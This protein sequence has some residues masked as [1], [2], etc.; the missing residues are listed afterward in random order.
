M[1]KI[2][3]A[4]VGSLGI[5]LAAAVAFAAPG[6]MGPGM[7]MHGPMGGMMSHDAA[8]GADMATVHELLVDHEGIR[9]TVTNLSNGIRTVT[10]SDDPR[11]AGF[12]RAHVASMERR[13]ADGRPFNMF[14]PTLPILFANKDRIETAVEATAKG[15]VVTQTSS[16][17]KV[18]AALQ[19]HAGEVSKLARDG[20]AAMMRSA[21]ASMA[22]TPGSPSQLPM[23]DPVAHGHAAGPGGDAP[24]ADRRMEVEFPPELRDHT[25]ANMRDH[26]RTLQEIQATLAAG[27]L[28][29]AADI[30]ERRL[31]MS[32]LAAHGAHEVA[33]YMP[34]GMQNAGSAMHRSASRFAIAA[35]DASAT[36]DLKPA[37]AALAEVTA[38]CVACHAA[39]RL[40]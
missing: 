14:S 28:D 21:Q 36:S 31:G 10:E 9:R 39:Y 26:L 22:A 8:S 24:A 11:L 4:V 16:D 40:K 35:Q 27:K 5:A 6:G 30:A 3:I 25:L 1:G 17:P 13:L 33:K 12:I 18:V 37:L 19:A 23:H 38:N 2:G 20:M 34:E 7:M 32:S 15:S 29:Q